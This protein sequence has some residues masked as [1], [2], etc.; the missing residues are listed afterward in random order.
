MNIYLKVLYF[1]KKESCAVPILFIIREKY[2]YFDVYYLIPRVSDN[3]QSSFSALRRNGKFVFWLC[4]FTTGKKIAGK[5]QYPYF[6]VY[7]FIPVDATIDN[8][9]LAH[10]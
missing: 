8:R 9:A 3:R 1:I 4:C 10:C 2:P 6:D 7:F 5:E